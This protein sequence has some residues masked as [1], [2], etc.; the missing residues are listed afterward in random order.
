MII[1]PLS[2]GS[3]K[4]HKDSFHEGIR[5]NCDQCEYVTTTKALLKFHK[6]TIHDGVRKEIQIYYKTVSP[7]LSCVL[8]VEL[9]PRIL[10]QNNRLGHKFTITLEKTSFYYPIFL[11]H[12]HLLGNSLAVDQDP[13]PF[14]TSYYI[15]VKGFG[16]SWIIDIDFR[17]QCDHCGY[18]CKH[19]KSLTHHIQ[20]VHFGKGKE[21]IFVT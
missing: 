8:M 14:L 17:L 3:L 1:K 11:G 2:L 13:E 18:T 16:S 5:H 12:F 10:L 9:F 21:Y 4:H 6:R 7:R 20:S 19:K 15:K